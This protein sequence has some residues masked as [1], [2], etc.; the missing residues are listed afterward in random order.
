MAYREHSIN[1][2]KIIFD[3]CVSCKYKSIISYETDSILLLIG[4]Y[5]AVVVFLADIDTNFNC[6]S[7]D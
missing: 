3:A 6:K 7:I 4:L 2:K 1:E 5:L